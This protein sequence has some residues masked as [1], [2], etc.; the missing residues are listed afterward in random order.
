MQQNPNGIEVNAIQSLLSAGMALGKVQSNPHPEG[1][2]FVMLPSKDGGVAVVY[3]ERPDMPHRMKGAVKVNDTESF[4]TA[5]NRHSKKP[6]SVIYAA[7]HPACFTAVLNDHIEKSVAQS[8]MGNAGWRDHRVIYA[9]ANSKEHNVWQGSAKKDMAQD[10]FAYFIEDN[11][12]DFKTP[13]GAKMLEIATNFRVKQGIA[14]KS[15]IRLQDSQVQLEYTEQNEGGGGRSGNMTIPETFKIEI[16]IFDGIEAKKYLMEVRL[17]Y[18]VSQGT[19]AIRYELVRPH[20]VIE[21][22]FKEVLE[23]IRKGLKDAPIIFGSPD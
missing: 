11:L 5:A 7:L 22:A 4:V 18:R 9:L 16:P 21:Q 6:E 17:R 1:K 12:P 3:L 23:D 2:G 13:D 20:K 15:N 14:F 8:N 10:A 19:L